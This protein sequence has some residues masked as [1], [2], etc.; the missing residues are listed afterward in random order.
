MEHG[1]LIVIGSGPAGEKGAELIRVASQ[2]M[3]SGGSVKEFV[4]AVYN[5]PTLTDVYKSAAFDGLDKLEQ[6]NA[7]HS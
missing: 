4:N 5:Y 6:W 3:I 1:D 2:V 7:A